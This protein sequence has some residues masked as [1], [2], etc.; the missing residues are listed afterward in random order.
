M[1]VVVVVIVAAAVA[2]A[3]ALVVVEVAT[4]A[5]VVALATVVVVMIVVA[6]LSLTINYFRSPKTG[7]LIFHFLF[8]SVPFPPPFFLKFRFLFLFLNKCIRCRAYTS[9]HFG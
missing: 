5:A 2:E 3:A 9:F 6:R 7:F 8:S 4:A 1:V